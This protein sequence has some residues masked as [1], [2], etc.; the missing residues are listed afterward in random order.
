[1][2]HHNIGGG[3]SIEM[4][5]SPFAARELPVHLSV[6]FYDFMRASVDSNNN[7]RDLPRSYRQQTPVVQTKR[8]SANNVPKGFAKELSGSQSELIPLT[9]QMLQACA[10][11]ERRKL[12]GNRLFRKIEEMHIENTGKITGV[13]LEMDNDD[14]LELL[15]SKLKLQE[16]VNEAVRVVN[17]YTMRKSA[18]NQGTFKKKN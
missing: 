2:N 15:R 16:K 7:S 14:L 17:D 13:L 3:Q 1:M 12:I 10:P 4:Q 8:D 5:M 11:S 18:K 9:A 6:P